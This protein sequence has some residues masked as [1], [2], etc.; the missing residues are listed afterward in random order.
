MA[1]NKG[2]FGFASNFEVKIQEMLDPRG[3][4]EFKSD[5]INKDTWPHDGDTIYMKEGMLVTVRSTR[6]VFMLVS[7]DKILDPDYSGWERKDGTGSGSGT[8]GEA[9]IDP[10]LL[11]AY[12]PM[13]RDFSD[14]FNNDFAR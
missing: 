13:S 14:D 9:T 6:E 1:R 10:E 8:G 4:V 5:L 12:I 2:T 7:L 3:G 11:E